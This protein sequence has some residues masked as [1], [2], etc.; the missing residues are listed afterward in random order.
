MHFR[1]SDRTR[2]TLHIVFLVTSRSEPR[3]SLFRKCWKTWKFQES[4]RLSGNCWGTDTSFW[5][6][7]V[8]SVNLCLGQYRRLLAYR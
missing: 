8:D 5:D 1:G 4:C 2:Y 6:N 3:W 7:C